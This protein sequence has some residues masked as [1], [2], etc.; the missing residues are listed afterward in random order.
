MTLLTSPASWKSS[1]RYLSLELNKST[2]SFI[3]HTTRCVTP[4]AYVGCE[5]LIMQAKNISHRAYIPL[6]VIRWPLHWRAEIFCQSQHRLQVISLLRISCRQHSMIWAVNEKIVCS[7][8]GL[9]MTSCAWHFSYSEGYSQA[10]ESHCS[11]PCSTRR[12]CLVSMPR[13]PLTIWSSTNSF[14]PRVYNHSEGIWF[15]NW[16]WDWG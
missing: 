4:V 13:H 12:V 9:G 2:G 10:V 8:L 1:F 7:L 14:L 6:C 15:G 16:D 3:S 11:T 5:V